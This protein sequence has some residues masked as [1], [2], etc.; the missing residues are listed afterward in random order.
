[1][2][3]GVTGT[4]SGMTKEQ[5]ASVQK[6]I[7]EE[8]CFRPDVLEVHHGDCY[9][10]DVEFAEMFQGQPHTRVICHPPIKEGLRAFHRSDEVLDPYSCFHRNRNIVDAVDLLIVIPFQDC[11]QSDGGTWYTH[12]YA[13]KVGKNR[14]VLWPDGDTTTTIRHPDYKQDEV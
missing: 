7:D 1:M 13:K 2:K 14:K 8:L 4:R 10:V 6:L 9:G 12:D 11:W 3:I 5:K